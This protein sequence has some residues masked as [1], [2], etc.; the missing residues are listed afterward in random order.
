MYNFALDIQNAQLKIIEIKYD[1]HRLLTAA[2]ILS[3]ARWT[4]SA[5]RPCH[6]WANR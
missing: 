5:L 2:S 1:N 4:L 3:I 6:S